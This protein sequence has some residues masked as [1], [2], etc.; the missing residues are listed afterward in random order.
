MAVMMSV[1]MEVVLKVVMV[2]VVIVVVGSV[3]GVQGIQRVKIHDPQIGQRNMR[4]MTRTRRYMDI[5]AIVVS[6]LLREDCVLWLPRTFEH[7]MSL[8]ESGRTTMTPM[9][10]ANLK[11]GLYEKAQGFLELGSKLNYSE[12]MRYSLTTYATLT[13]LCDLLPMSSSAIEFSRGLS[14]I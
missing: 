7:G 4:G 10:Q 6:Y 1:S 12:L 5:A 3:Q 2:V 9:W 11:V 14:L 13:L 8:C